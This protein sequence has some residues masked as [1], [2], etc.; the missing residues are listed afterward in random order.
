MKKLFTPVVFICLVLSSATAQIAPNHASEIN[1]KNSWLKAGLNA[2]VPFADLADVS[3]FVLG[4]ELK[5]Q[6]MSTKNIG[7]GLSS[8]Y[9]HFFP[10]EGFS[11]WGTIPAA[12][13]IRYYPHR[14][15]FFAGADLGYGFITSTVN[16]KGGLYARPQLGYHNRYWNF[17]GF[18]NGIFRSAGNGGHLQFAG[19]GAT[20]NL[21]F[22]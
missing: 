15:G 14:T 9:N 16:N 21:M 22:N 20:Y 18:Y 17:F 8:G 1:R 12:A 3:R 2:G 13:F 10:K 11:N 19:V 5:G 4:V 7:I 6:L